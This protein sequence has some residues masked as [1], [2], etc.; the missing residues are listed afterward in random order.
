MSTSNACVAPWLGL[1]ELPV[2]SW[3]EPCEGEE[4]ERYGL[5]WK[6]RS[7]LDRADGRPFVWVD[8]E[9]TDADRAWTDAH[10]PGEALLHRVDPRFGLTEADFA[11]LDRWLRLHAV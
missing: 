3:P 7:L 10:H 9:I 6:T 4:E 1:P 5:H 11:V 8:D 2:V